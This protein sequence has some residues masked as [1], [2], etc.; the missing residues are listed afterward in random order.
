MG[1]PLYGIFAKK[2]VANASCHPPLVTPLLQF[3]S[4]YLKNFLCKLLKK[5]KYY[6]FILSQF[7][8]FGLKK[9]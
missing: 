7:H 3:F 2:I 5:Y 1:A 9:L 8:L 6:K 4:D